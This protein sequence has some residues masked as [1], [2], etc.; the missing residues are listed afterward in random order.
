MGEQAP[1][2]ITDTQ[3]A[4]VVAIGGLLSFKRQWPFYQPLL[5]DSNCE[6][7]VQERFLAVPDGGRGPIDEM[8]DQLAE[9]LTDAHE[10]L[11]GQ[12]FVLAGHSLG[13]LMAT[14]LALEHSDKIAGAICVAGAQEGI[15][16]ETP[17]SLFLR[18]ALRHPPGEKHIKHDSEFMMDHKSR[19]ATEWPADT[20]LHLVSATYDDLLLHPQ[21]LQLELPDSQTPERRIIAPP[22]MS[23]L[24]RRIPGMP[25]D[26]E[27]IPSY[28]VGHID[29]VRSPALLAYV[30]RVRREAAAPDNVVNLPTAALPAAA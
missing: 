17:S 14:M 15:R 2:P 28:P 21:G 19:V 20:P 4:P 29:I 10:K 18:A 5:K 24:Y 30:R 23:W 16:R 9:D 1:A 7:P 11:D 12:R 8:H 25:K 13:G 3:L 26:V 22:G 6:V 27:F